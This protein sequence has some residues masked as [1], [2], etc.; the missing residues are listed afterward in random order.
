MSGG[1]RPAPRWMRDPAFRGRVL[2]C[3]GAMGTM[4]HSAG[5]PLDRPVCE[6]NMSQP[7]LVRD[8]HES[9]LAAGADII[10]TNT[11]DANQLRLARVGLQDQ[12]MEITIAGGRL[13]REAARECGRPALVA[14]S[15]GPV[16]NAAAPRISDEARASM[17]AGQVAALADWV[18]FIL[19]ETFGDVESLAQ[20]VRVALAGCDLPVFAQMTFGEDGRTLRGEEPATV[21]AA[22]AALDVGAVGVNCTVGPAAL[23]GV[24]RQL[25]AGCQLPVIVQPNAGMPRRLGRQLRYAHNTDYFAECARRFAADGATVVGGCCGTTPAH[26]RA[27]ARAVAGVPAGRPLGVVA[28]RS[29]AGTLPL[30]PDRASPVTWPH[31]GL[32][33]LAGMPV[34][35]GQDVPQFVAQA[36]QLR[37]AGANLITI[38]GRGTP[39]TRINPVA[40]AVVLRERLGIEVMLQVEAAGRSPAALE[41]DLLGAYALGVRTV[42]CRT[43]SPRVAGDYPEAYGLWDVDSVRLISALAGLNDGI[44]WRGHA[45]PERTRFVIGAALDISA[46]DTGRELERIEGKVRAGAHFLLTDIIYDPDSCLRVLAELRGRGIDLPVIITLAPFDDPATIARH[47]HEFPEVSPPSPALAALRGGEDLA[48]RVNSAFETMHKLDDLASGVLI[49][50][51]ARPDARMTRLIAML[52]QRQAAQEAP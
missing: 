44:D 39:T 49:H 5:V 33:V 25:T 7:Q 2:V 42:V 23:R 9:Y 38:T 30:K 14:G 6:L 1:L 45:T 52:A 17:L 3:D 13:A 15:V 37:A 47:I 51:P 34:P 20:A 29:A 46:T 26:V 8:L 11:F 22:I 18:D 27:V 40:A 31:L 4:L 48:H 21:A 32:V 12:V 35:R 16:M 50:A 10:Q 19:L 43:G 36:Q 24:V 41:A 28:P